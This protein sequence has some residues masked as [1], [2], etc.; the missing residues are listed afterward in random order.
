MTSR[1]FANV[2]STSCCPPC[3]GSN[4][5]PP[6]EVVEHVAIVPRRCRAARR[7][8]DVD[9]ATSSEVPF[10]VFRDDRQGPASPT[11]VTAKGTTAGETIS[12]TWTATFDTWH[13]IIVTS[14]NGLLGK[15]T[16]TIE[17]IP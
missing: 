14:L 15:Y 11:L 3:R 2:S 13:E 5:I 7:A 12:V 4:A 17:E 1:C 8:G 16:L 10:L 9:R 6:R